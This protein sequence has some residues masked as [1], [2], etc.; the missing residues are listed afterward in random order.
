MSRSLETFGTVEELS[1]KTFNVIEYLPNDRREFKEI[2][3]IT[4]VQ[5]I[6]LTVLDEE[7]K[8][9][10]NNQFFMLTSEKGIKRFEELLNITPKITDTLDDRQ[11]RVLARYNS[12]IPYTYENVVKQLTILCGE[13]GFTCELI[14]D[15]YFLKVR[16]ELLVKV[17]FLE[18]EKLL[19]RMLPANIVVDLDLRYNQY[20]TL[21]RFTYGQLG[22]FTHEYLRN[23]YLGN[24]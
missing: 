3:A 19:S 16:V 2:K 17:M 23:E 22:A 15:E 11:F 10:K 13:D 20:Q 6:E 8:D 4:S 9:L 14:N 5:N 24:L 7:I 12:S 18:V 1:Q 21:E